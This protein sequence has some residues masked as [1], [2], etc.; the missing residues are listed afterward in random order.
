VPTATGAPSRTWCSTDVVRALYLGLLNREPDASGLTAWQRSLDAG[1]SLHEVV[2]QFDGS[3]ERDAVLAKR[4]RP[5]KRSLTDGPPLTIVD[6]GAQPLIDEDDIFQPLLES[7]QCHVIGFEPLEE[8]HQHRLAQNPSW[9]L[10]P[11]FLG[12]GSERTFYETVWGPT[13]SLY[14]PDNAALA[15]FVGLSESCVVS[16]SRVVQTV[17][18]D[19]VVKEQVDFLKID[20]QGA[21]LDVLR[22]STKL[23]GE[24]LVIHVEVQFFPLYRGV[25]LFDQVFS[26]L[27]NHSFEL[28]DFPRLERYEYQHGTGRLERLLWADAVFIPSKGRLDRLDKDGRLKLTRIMN[29]VYGATGF[30]QWLSQLPYLSS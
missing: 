3:P 23:L 4:R 21:E 29:D 24:I 8:T 9:S 6:V 28:F 25:P 7:G 5:S 2:S 12:D 14:E 16:Q 11:F 26:L 19:D 15:D 20:V 13:S 1:I 10:L 27:L 22:G 18:L 17:R 30:G